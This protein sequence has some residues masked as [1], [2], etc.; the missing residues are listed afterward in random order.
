MISLY[1]RLCT[2]ALLLL[3]LLAAPAYAAE[4]CYT[5]SEMDAASRSGIEAAAQQLFSAAASGNTAAM[6]QNSIA[7]IANNFQ[8]IA[9]AVQGNKDKIAAG[10]AHIRNE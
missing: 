8:G 2:A 9:N 10:Q 1:S 6:Q 5:V 3:P 7:A 4:S